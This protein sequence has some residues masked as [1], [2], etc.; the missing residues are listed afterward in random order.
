MLQNGLEN[1]VIIQRAIMAQ[2]LRPYC[3]EP[4]QDSE[5]S[6]EKEPYSGG[7]SREA[8]RNV[9]DY[10][11][12][13]RSVRHNDS[14][15]SLKYVVRWHGY[16]EADDTTYCSTSSTSTAVDSTSAESEKPI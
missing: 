10:Y 9:K 13:D 3:D 6:T 12:V 1:T 4:K 11:V 14:W 2:N 8:H 7:D 5:G 16:S 15:P